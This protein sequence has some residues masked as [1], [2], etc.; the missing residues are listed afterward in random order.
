MRDIF[1]H[2]TLLCFPWRHSFP[3]FY[4]SEKVPF[5]APT[6]WLI[7]LLSAAS[8]GCES[9]A[10][11]PALARAARGWREFPGPL[12]PRLLAHRP[13]L[14]RGVNDSSSKTRRLR[15]FYHPPKQGLRARMGSFCYKA[16]LALHQREIISINP[17]QNGRLNGVFLFS[18]PPAP[19][20]A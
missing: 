9:L 5:Q 12:L 1:S 13:P 15:D 17:L 18:P 6:Q 16:T 8:A 3:H 11:V 20:P 10:A 19:F 7:S 2:R 14:P 4:R